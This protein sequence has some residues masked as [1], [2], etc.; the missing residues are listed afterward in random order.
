M[1]RIPHTQATLEDG[2][3]GFGLGGNAN[4]PRVLAIRAG[5]PD[6]RPAHLAYLQNF[7]ISES[8]P[9]LPFL[10]VRSRLKGSADVGVMRQNAWRGK[11]GSRGPSKSLGIRMW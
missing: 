3:E 9:P 8:P 10:K 1:A 6:S 11:K 7:R 4:M 2:V 5:T